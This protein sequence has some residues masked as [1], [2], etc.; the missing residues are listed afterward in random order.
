MEITSTEFREGE[1]I[2]SKYS[3]DGQ[4]ISPPLAW[5]DIPEGTKSLALIADDPDAP[6]KT[7]VHWVVYDIPPTVNGFS[8]SVA[9]SEN[10]EGG[11]TQGVND[12]K[13]IG[14]GGPCPPSGEHRYYFKLYALDRVLNESPGL[15]KQKLEQLM[16][17]KILDQ[18]SLMGTYAR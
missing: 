18:C 2:P 17:G 8:E 16:E 7:W 10:L 13:R 3:C 12:F 15:S 6:G 9:A 11:G 14:Y 5:K 1:P 4:D